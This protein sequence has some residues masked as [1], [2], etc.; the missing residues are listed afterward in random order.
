TIF[1]LA[2]IDNVDFKERS[3][4]FGNIYD[5]TR[6]TSHATLRMAFQ[7]SLPEVINENPESTHELNIDTQIFGISKEMRDIIVKFNE[8]FI[9][10]LAF[11][12]NER[13]ELEYYKFDL[14]A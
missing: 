1:N 10:L 2:V 12:F 9:N 8:I 6:G 11:Q 7:F 3:F 4:Q 14:T 13:Q 5:V